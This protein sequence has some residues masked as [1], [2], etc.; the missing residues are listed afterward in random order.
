MS[1]KLSES[2]KALELA[3]EREK[4][5]KTKLSD[6]LDTAQKELCHTRSIALKNRYSRRR[7]LI[8]LD[9]G[10]NLMC[11]LCEIEHVCVRCLVCLC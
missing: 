8:I 5:Y 10:S 2:E 3:R 7:V 9:K 4:E 1:A 6:E 11:R